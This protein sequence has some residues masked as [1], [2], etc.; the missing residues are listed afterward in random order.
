LG[1]AYLRALLTV[2]GDFD[3]IKILGPQKKAIERE[4]NQ[5]AAAFSVKTCFLAWDIPQGV[6]DWGLCRPGKPTDL[7]ICSSSI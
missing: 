5:G 7:L 1:T 3:F 6:E 2:H 4:K